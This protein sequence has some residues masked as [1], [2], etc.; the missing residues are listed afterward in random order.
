MEITINDWYVYN[1]AHDSKKPIFVAFKCDK[2][3]TIIGVGTYYNN[4]HHHI[5]CHK[6]MINN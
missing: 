3:K 2:I 6:I 4:I 1:T 5:W